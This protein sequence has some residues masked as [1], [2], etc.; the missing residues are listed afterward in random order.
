[1]EALNNYFETEIKNNT[2]RIF[3]ILYCGFWC[4]VSAVL[5]NIIFL[6][7]TREN[8]NNSANIFYFYTEYRIII[9]F[10]ERLKFAFLALQFKKFIDFANGIRCIF[11]KSRSARCFGILMAAVGE[12][13]ASK[14]A[15]N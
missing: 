2:V 11:A 6:N 4:G 15:I 5:S 1:M 13:L 14:V 8:K 10:N 12:S 9:F 3:D 7:F